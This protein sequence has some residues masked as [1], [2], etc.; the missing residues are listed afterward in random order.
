MAWR[1]Q[2]GSRKLCWSRR[3]WDWG[4]HHEQQAGGVTQPPWREVSGG[5]AANFYI[6]VTTSYFFLHPRVTS[7]S[8]ASPKLCSC[9]IFPYSL[10]AHLQAAPSPT[11]SSPA[12]Q[13]LQLRKGSLRLGILLEI[14][15]RDSVKKKG[16]EGAC[17]QGW[18]GRIAT[19]ATVRGNLPA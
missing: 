14:W 17:C 2:L 11:C 19:V 8:P 9:P 1:E 10:H 6:P 18:A 15:G 12:C 13:S 4:G 5:R 16:E 3:G 7:Y